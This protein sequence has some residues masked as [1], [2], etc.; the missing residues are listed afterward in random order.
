M[1]L[2]PAIFS[3]LF[4][5]TISV[6]GKVTGPNNEPLQGA[7]ISIKGTTVTTTTNEAGNYSIAVP[8]IGGVL[9]VSHIG[10]EELKK[11]V[12]YLKKRKPIF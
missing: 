6:T 9:V 7:T 12:T 3:N 8:K 1:F 10:M 4:A 11:T 2:V 5:Q